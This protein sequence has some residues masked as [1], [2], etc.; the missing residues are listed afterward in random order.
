MHGLASAISF[1]PQCGVP[2]KFLVDK[3]TD[4]RFEPG[5]WAVNQQIPYAKSILDYIFRRLG[6]R[7]L[8]P[9][10]RWAPSAAPS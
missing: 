1:A 10:P 6:A 5:G 2:L 9:T 8:G 3:F 4:V 7:L